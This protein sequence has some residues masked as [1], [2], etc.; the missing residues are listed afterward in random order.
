MVELERN[1]PHLLVSG[2]VDIREFKRPGRGDFKVRDLEDRLAHGMRLANETTQAFESHDEHK[3][4]YDTAELESL[5]VLLAIEGAPGFSL[6][7]EALDQRSRHKSPIP[8][9]ILLSVKLN[10]EDDREVAQVWVSDEYRS[11]FLEAFDRF[12]NEDDK[13]NGKPKNRRLV[14]NIA[15]VRSALLRDLWQ[16]DDQPPMTGRHWWEIWLRPEEQ[17]IDRARAFAESVGGQTSPR[18]LR[19]D[20][21]WMVIHLCGGGL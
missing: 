3:A 18:C 5:G 7:L 21:R 16:S 9:W 15:Q 4:S 14:S 8:K 11:A 19:F 1:R 20:D 10:V 17:A 2:Y 6:H 13:R 12:A